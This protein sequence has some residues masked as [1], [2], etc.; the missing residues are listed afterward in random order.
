MEEVRYN[1]N[2]IQWSYKDDCSRIRRLRDDLR[3][4]APRE[5]LFGCSHL[6][7][8]L[9]IY[10]W[11]LALVSFTALTLR[12]TIVLLTPFLVKS[13]HYDTVFVLF[14]SVITIQPSRYGQCPEF[15][16]GRKASS[17]KQRDI[18]GR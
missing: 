16:R 1:E 2:G 8:P 12:L 10:F 15:C 17:Y 3:D 7:L 13:I 5:R 9:K 6:W 14:L 4:T 18:I 11:F